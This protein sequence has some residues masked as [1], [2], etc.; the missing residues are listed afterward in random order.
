MTKQDAFESLRKIDN[1]SKC[2]EHP[3]LKSIVHA[4]VA[5]ESIHPS[6]AANFEEN[7]KR[8]SKDPESVESKRRRMVESYCVNNNIDIGKIPLDLKEAF[9]GHDSTDLTEDFMKDFLKLGQY[10]TE[11]SSEDPR[12]QFGGASSSNE[13]P[14]PKKKAMKRKSKN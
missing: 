7:L 4:I 8:E 11:E 13:P 9:Y 2:K 14:V 5:S 6:E 12:Y 1:F 3:V 10:S